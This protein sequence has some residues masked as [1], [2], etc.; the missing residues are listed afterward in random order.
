MY[1]LYHAFQRNYNVDVK[2]V[3]LEYLNER[4]YLQLVTLFNL[5]SFHC[6]VR[7]ET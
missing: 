5:S 1:D 3:K 6:E 2:E 4:I 7:F